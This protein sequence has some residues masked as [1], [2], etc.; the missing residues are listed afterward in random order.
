[1]CGNAGAT[2]IAV[3][4]TARVIAANADIVNTATVSSST[5]PNQ[6][7][8]NPQSNIISGSAAP[9]EVP[10]LSDWQHALLAVVLALLALTF[11]NRYGQLRREQK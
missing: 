4:A 7:I 9:E 1:M 2:P 5:G 8:T 10:A 3:T 11:I 6:Q